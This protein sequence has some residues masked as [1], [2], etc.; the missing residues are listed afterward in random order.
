MGKYD[1]SIKMFFS[2]LF[3]TLFLLP[4]ETSTQKFASEIHSQYSGNVTV[5]EISVKCPNFMPERMTPTFEQVL[6]LNLKLI[7][8]HFISID[9]SL[10]EMSFNGLVEI[11]WSNA[12]C[13]HGNQFVR[14]GKMTKLYPPPN[15]FWKPLINMLQSQDM[16]LMGGDRRETLEIIVQNPYPE[17]DPESDG[18]VSIQWKWSVMGVYTFHCDL[19]LFLFP[20]DVQNCTLQLQTQQTSFVNEFTRCLVATSFDEMPFTLENSNWRLLDTVCTIQFGYSLSSLLNVSFRMARV[21][22]FYMIHLVAP[23]FLLVF[24]ELCSFALPVKGAERTTYTMTIY[25]AFIFLESMLLTILPQTPKRILLSEYILFQ[26]T[27]STIVTI[28]SA[29]ICCISHLI[30]SNFITICSMKMSWRFILDFTAFWLSV[31]AFTI[32]TS[33]IMGQIDGSDLTVAFTNNDNVEFVVNK[34]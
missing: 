5:N 34:P 28:Y 1:I 9:N 12:E 22:A 4:T 14:D 3:S 18:Q 16:F 27:F 20:A 24:L 8:Y 32:E 26:S 31:L 13:H 17:S 11:M 7:P 30:C 21:P 6:S 33:Y 15:L 10:E 2:I 25:L 23:C 19:N 29:I